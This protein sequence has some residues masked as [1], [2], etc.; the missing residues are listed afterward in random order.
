MVGGL[1]DKNLIRATVGCRNQ[2]YLYPK[3]L[4]TVAKLLQYSGVGSTQG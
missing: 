3:A 2:Q 1:R 4:T